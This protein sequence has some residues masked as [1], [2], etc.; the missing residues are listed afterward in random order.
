MKF[1]RERETLADKAWFRGELKGE[2][3]NKT[4]K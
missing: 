1:V 3:D 2:S 4:L